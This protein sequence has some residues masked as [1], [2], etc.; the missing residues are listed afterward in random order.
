MV[1]RECDRAS[2]W[3]TLVSHRR[4]TWG[5]GGQKLFKVTATHHETGGLGDRSGFV[6]HRHPE[7]DL[8]V[9]VDVTCS[10]RLDDHPS[11]RAMHRQLQATLTD[12]AHRRWHL[13]EALQRL[14]R[15]QASDLHEPSKAFNVLES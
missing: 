15:D 4:E 3:D 9:T 1:N 8:D 6:R 10:Q 5:V 11:S 7:Q 14:P 13:S 12:D 2:R